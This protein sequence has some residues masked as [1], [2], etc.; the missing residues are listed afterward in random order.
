V[1][2]HRDLIA[3]ARRIAELELDHDAAL[4]QLDLLDLVEG[5]DAAL[6]LRGLGRVGLETLDE[7]LFLGEHRLLARVSGLA[8]GLARG[9]LT[10][11]EVVI[12]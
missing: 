9:P 12:A 1:F 5:L 7:A 6:H 8:I 10:L 11:V 4:R 3:G 2:D